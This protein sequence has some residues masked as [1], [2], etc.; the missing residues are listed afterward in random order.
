MHVDVP[1]S[2][3][4]GCYM[5]QFILKARAFL[6]ELTDY[7]LH[8]SF[9]HDAI[10]SLGIGPKAV[11]A[12]SVHAKSLRSRWQGVSSRMP[13]GRLLI[14]IRNSQDCSFVKCSTC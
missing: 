1:E 10:L 5:V 14:G 7:R 6:L 13:L 9:W 12:G 4:G 3:Q 8:Q 11:P 2:N